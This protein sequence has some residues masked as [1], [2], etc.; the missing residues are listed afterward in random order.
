[1]SANEAFGNLILF[2]IFKKKTK[3]NPV[4]L[5]GCLLINRGCFF[6]WDGLF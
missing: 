1:M 5:P 6:E 3:K 2:S 4:L